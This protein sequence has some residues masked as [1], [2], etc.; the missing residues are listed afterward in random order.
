MGSRGRGSSLLAVRPLQSFASS[1]VSVFFAVF[2]SVIGLPLWQ[3]GLVLTG[4]LLF[5]TFLNLVAG[6]LADQV[7]RRKM[8]VLFGLIAALSGGIFAG[9]SNPAI[10]I[11]TAIISTMGYRGGFGP[12]QMLERV[13][14][15]QTC[16]DEKRTRMY[17]I[18]STLSYLATSG[19]SLFT[20]MVVLLQSRFSLSELASYRVMFGLYALLNLGALI[21]YS[22]LSSRAEVE[23]VA[24]DRVVPL[25]PET[26]RN[27]LKLSLLFSMDSF[28]GG[29]ITSSLVSY[30]FFV[31]FGL[32]MD[33]I[34]VIF[35]ASSLLSA[36]SFILAARIA[37]RI[38]LINTMVF[39]HL[40]A[41]M[42][43]MMIPFM[44]NLASSILLYLSRALLSQMDVPTR[45]SYVMAIVKPE[46]RSRVAGI[47]NLPRSLTLAV[48]PSLAGFIMEFLG[49]SLPFPIAGGLKAAYDLTL[50]FTFKD[51]KP[52]EERR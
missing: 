4:G 1:F 51:V 28:G 34:G 29:L 13:I 41:N 40:P 6:F 5:S 18:R 45:Q 21:L 47:I 52:P 9:I 36:L 8:L 27:I 44:P 39:S 26:K 35:S 49:L 11:P 7:G 33:V 2:L 42:M 10:L 17:A 16:P 43:T 19:G 24:K 15:A 46:E 20:G 50:Y 12:I 3:I 22:Q 25:S 37:E 38:G 14:L 48:S 30:W 32:G 31:R 23:V